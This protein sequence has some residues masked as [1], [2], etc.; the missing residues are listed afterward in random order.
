MAKRVITREELNKN[1][2]GKTCWFAIHDVVYDITKFLEEVSTK[3]ITSTHVMMC[4][5]PMHLE[6]WDVHVE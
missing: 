5:H 2:S 4:G 6:C 3:M 1:N